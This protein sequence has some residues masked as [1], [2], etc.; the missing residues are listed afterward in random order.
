MPLAS[1]LNAPAFRPRLAPRRGTSSSRRCVVLRAADEGPEFARNMR[2]E[3]AKALREELDGVR[4]R[5][6]RLLAKGNRLVE[7]GVQLKAAAERVM[8]GNE[9]NKEDE[10]RRLLVERKKVK[11]TLDLTTARAEVL[12]ELASKLETAI[13]VLENATDEES[14]DAAKALAADTL[15]AAKR[16]SLQEFKTA[17]VS[18]RPAS[19]GEDDV[20][21]DSIAERFGRDSLEREFAALEITQLERM[22]RLT[23]ED[24]PIPSE[25]AVVKEDDDDVVASNTEPAWWQPPSEPEDAAGATM[26][27]RDALLE[28]DRARVSSKGVQGR[29]VV[30][31]RKSCA[32]HGA[33][34]IRGS[35]RLIGGKKDTAFRAGVGAALT[36]VETGEGETGWSSLGG[37]EPT[38]FL[39]DLARDLGVTPERAG[40][41]VANAT[42]RKSAAALLQAG[43]SVRGGE[44]ESARV[45]LKK[46][47]SVLQTFRAC[48]GECLDL[49]AFGLEQQLSEAERKIVL[50][51]V[52]K[53]TSEEVRGAIRCALGL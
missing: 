49:V 28:V 37:Y 33:G 35:D 9:I 21:Q 50:G 31:L 29:H 23:P 8:L 17:P 10:A 32:V 18:S 43:A 46:L 15:P 13:I 30:A 41:L 48:A 45:D 12:A 20:S 1:R 42:A 5:S 19:M 47:T 40:V 38:V 22:L 4:T 6:R 14:V 36:A 26:T 27:P 7:R 39:S 44:A 52:P 11:D 24:P 51:L 53:E 25:D 2:M 3:K 16:A 34:T